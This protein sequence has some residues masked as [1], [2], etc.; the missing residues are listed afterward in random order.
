VE[1]NNRG[2][3]K[4]SQGGK[5]ILLAKKPTDSQNRKEEIKTKRRTWTRR[6]M[7]V[8]GKVGCVTRIRG[9]KSVSNSHCGAELR[10][11]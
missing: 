7:I 6:K 9:K 4:K 10:N 8:F 3:R 1:S 11:Q 2:A 5:N